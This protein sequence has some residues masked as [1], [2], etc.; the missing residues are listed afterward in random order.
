MRWLKYRQIV[1]KQLTMNGLQLN[2]GQSH[3]KSIKVNQSGFVG[4]MRVDPTWR[5][6]K[7][8][9]SHRLDALA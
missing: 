9:A 2:P 4:L 6:G 8:R 5:M 1:R 3:S 7:L